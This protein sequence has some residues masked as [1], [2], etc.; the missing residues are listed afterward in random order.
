MNKISG[1]LVAFTLTATALLA[2]PV[3]NSVLNPASYALPGMPNYG[4]AQGGLLVAFGTGLGPGGYNAVSAFPLQKTLNGI[5]IRVT[6]ASTTVDCLPMNSYGAGSSATQV[7]ALLPSNTP[8]GDGTLVL[9]Y[10]GQAGAPAPIKVVQRAFGA[11][12][13]NAG[14]SGPAVITDAGYQV[15]LVTQSARPGQD[16]ILWGTGLGPI[17]ADETVGAPFHD[18]QE[19]ANISVYVGGMQVEI[20]YAG[21]A[22]S[23]AGLD[24]INFKVPQGVLGCYVPLVVTVNGVASNWTT[25]PVANSNG[26]CSDPNG[27]S[28][29]EL[30]AAQGRGSLRL[31]SVDLLRTAFTTAMEGFGTLTMTTDMAVAMF[32]RY[33]YAALIAAQGLGGYS[34][35]GAC[36]V[37][38][39]TGEGASDPVV[40]AG[41][42]PGAQ[43]SLTGPG[44]VRAIPGVAGQ[45]GDYGATLG[46]DMG[47]GMPNLFLAPGFYTA[48]GPGGADVGPFNATMTVPQALNWTNQA[49]ITSVNRTRPLQVTWTGGPPGGVVFI[50]GSSAISTPLQAGAS[51]VCL[52]QSNAGQFT[53][54]AMVL[55]ALPASETQQGMP[56]GQLSLGAASPPVRFTAPGLDVG[57]FTNSSVT[58]KMIA[59][60]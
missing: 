3:V 9:T 8:V 59:Y 13:V 39:F 29:A 23:A 17:N 60:Q 51:F 15:R 26:A 56:T 49:S 24:Q 32:V 53:I 48:T 54:P 33:D 7:V 43:L 2:Q 57:M 25:M 18:M 31:G 1:L 47:F 20:D 5:S 16:V 11:T 6:V 35:V 14:G 42:D 27:L 21:R 34:T 19:E 36:V 58:G 50:M 55:S 40:P 52:A 12:A 45:R 38:Q 37:S 46:Q 28:D 44:G 10:N 30:A 4:I 22:P 41:L